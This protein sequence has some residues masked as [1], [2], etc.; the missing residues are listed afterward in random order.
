MAAVM[1]VIV[2]TVALARLILNKSYAE[3]WMSPRQSKNMIIT[4]LTDEYE[5]HGEL[6]SRDL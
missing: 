4:I 6:G 2:L 3:E 1:P 5:V